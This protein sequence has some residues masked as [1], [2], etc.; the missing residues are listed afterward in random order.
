M[1]MLRSYFDQFVKLNNE[2][3]QGFESCLQARSIKKG[4]YLLKEGEVCNFIAF[5]EL[6]AFR[7]YLNRDGEEVMLGFYFKGDFAGNYRSFLVDQ[8]SKESIQAL[9]DARV[10]LIYKL[11]LLQLY[12]KFHKADRLGRM[13]AEQLF[14]TMA[15]RM[16]AMQYATPEERYKDMLSR[17]SLL[18]K[19]V[20]QYMLASYL[21]V[22]PET[23]SRI[24]ARK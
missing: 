21:G 5:V 22:K 7:F 23:L 17:N 16:D 6:G 13:V 8:P 4:D 9:K 12:D 1:Q 20:P 3:W 11:D 14:L 19:E 2:E 18:L 24:R 10:H 15:K